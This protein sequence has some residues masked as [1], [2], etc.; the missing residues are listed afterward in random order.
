MLGIVGDELPYRRERRRIRGR[1]GLVTRVK[2][3]GL[4]SLFMKVLGLG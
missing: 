3:L 2:A 4:I 1:F